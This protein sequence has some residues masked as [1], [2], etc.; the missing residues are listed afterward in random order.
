[1]INHA[2]K[3]EHQH[4][5]IKVNDFHGEVCI[6]YSDTE[7]CYLIFFRSS[8][9]SPCFTSYAASKVLL[10]KQKTTKYLPQYIA[11]KQQVNS[12]ISN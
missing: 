6:V 9:L 11:P 8:N 12:H 3:F 1:M 7:L 10:K 5:W 4:G 2:I